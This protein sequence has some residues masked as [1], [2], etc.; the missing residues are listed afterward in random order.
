MTRELT[1]PAPGLREIMRLQQSMSELP[2]FELPVQHHFTAGAYGR[3]LFVPAGVML[4]GKLHRTEHFLLVVGDVEIINGAQ[5]ERVTGIRVMNTKPGTKRAI[6]A[7]A[8][9]TLFTFH[10]TD[11][12]DVEAIEEEIIEPDPVE[13]LG[14]A[15]TPALENAA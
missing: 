4:V 8:D 2:Q 12:K 1:K 11:L 13:L 10:V 5:R 15:E 6:Y 14:G 7:H 3:Q 9:S